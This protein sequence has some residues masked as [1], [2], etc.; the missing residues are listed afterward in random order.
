MPRGPTSLPRCDLPWRG[1]LPR[2]A[3]PALPRTQQSS[4]LPA[5]LARVQQQPYPVLKTSVDVRGEEFRANLPANTAAVDKLR[6]ALASATVGGG[7][8]YT[9]R[10]VAAGKLLPRAR[11]ELLLDRDSHFLELCALAGKD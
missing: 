5:K 6:A 1:K 2:R 3:A 7:D 8:K 10:H 9:S 11:I 4:A